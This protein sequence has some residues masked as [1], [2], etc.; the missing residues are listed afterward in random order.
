M[1]GGKKAFSFFPSS[2]QSY[3]TPSFWDRSEE[4]WIIHPT[5]PPGADYD[6]RSSRVQMV[7]IY[8][9]ISWPV[10]TTRLQLTKKKRS[11]LSKGS[12]YLQTAPFRIWTQVTDNRYAKYTSEK[13]YNEFEINVIGICDKKSI[14]IKWQ[15][16]WCTR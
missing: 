16:F 3:I 2:G 12:S 10:A 13:E 15:P 14:G 8:S 5:P 7:W 9:F 11:C 1:K 6:T 4:E